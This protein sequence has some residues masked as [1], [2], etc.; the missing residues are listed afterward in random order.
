MTAFQSAASWQ[1]RHFDEQ[2][3]FLLET[4]GF[5][6][7]QPFT[8]DTL[9]VEFDA[10]VVTPG[11]TVLWAEFKG[12][13]QGE[14]PGLRRTDTAKKAISTGALLHAWSDGPGYPFVVL[15][16][17]LPASGS[18]G[19]RMIELAQAAGYVDQVTCVNDVEDWRSFITRWSVAS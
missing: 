2:C 3:R 7:S 19:E 12:S 15:T 6:V 11:G 17:H 8:I 10:E 4:S 16:S 14:R 1:G 5:K 9:G 13:F 18:A